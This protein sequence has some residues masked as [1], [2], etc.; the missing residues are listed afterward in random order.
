MKVKIAVIGFALLSLT[1]EQSTENPDHDTAATRLTF[2]GDCSLFTWSRN[3]TMIAV[4]RKSDLWIFDAGS[5]KWEQIASRNA[6]VPPIG[7]SSWSPDGTQLVYEAYHSLYK[8]D[9]ASKDST[10]LPIAGSSPRWSVDGK[11]LFFIREGFLAQ[12][13]YAT[14]A[15]RN[16]FKYDNYYQD[17]DL[18]PDSN[19]I[20]L[21]GPISYFNLEKGEIKP[22]NGSL[23]GENAGSVSIS[24][25]GK[26]FAY[27]KFSYE[28]DVVDV[29]K[30]F[31]FSDSSSTYVPN[32]EACYSPGWSPDS[33]RIAYLFKQDIWMKELST[34]LN[35]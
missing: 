2:T 23:G 13:L 22:L 1:C 21:S 15:A 3:G 8:V 5:M 28:D 16:L 30:V 17:Y 32:S 11:S 10:P 7:R 33:K 34:F 35:K 25:D 18:F 27:V 6:G 12:Y 9:V 14:Q 31:S 20:L 29:M 26:H 24:P 19:G 4:T